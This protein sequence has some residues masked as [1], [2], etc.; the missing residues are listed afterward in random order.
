MEDEFHLK[1]IKSL[2]ELLESA[3]DLEMLRKVIP[4][5]H[6]LWNHLEGD[7]KEATNKMKRLANLPDKF[8]DHFADRGWIIYEN[9]NADIAEK[10]VELAEDGNIKSAEEAL[11][12]YYDEETINFQLNQ[13]SRIDA[14]RPRYD[15]A[16]KALDDYLAGRYH[17]CIPITLFLLDGLV[18][19]IDGQH[20]FFSGGS[21]I[22]AWDS[23]SAHSKGLEK[24][25]DIMK[26]GRKKTNTDEITIPYRNGILHGTDLNYDNKVVAAKSWNAL[27][28]IYD[29]AHKAENG[30]LDPPEEEDND[31]TLSETLEKLEKVQEKRGKID[32]WQ[33]RKV[34]VGEDTPENPLPEDLEEDTP[35]RRALEFLA[36]WKDDNYGYMAKFIPPSDGIEEGKAPQEIRE[37]YRN[38]DMKDFSLQGIIDKAAAIT[39]VKVKVKMVQLGKEV[40]KKIDLRMIRQDEDGNSPFRNDPNGEW[41]IGNWSTLGS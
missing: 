31:S 3:E 16:Q 1:Y 32:Q 30:E 38:H 14:F 25:K 23:I 10:A 27:F 21:E 19:D 5:S 18:Q 6:P 12:D 11:V 9:M 17:S 22:D 2:K 41:Y 24:L 34:E 13:M 4:A 36:Y 26:T 20:S 39:V 40:T 29:W 7:P 28:A 33:P 8:N 37:F 35:E 15:L